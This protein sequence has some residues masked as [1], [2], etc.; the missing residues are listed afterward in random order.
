MRSPPERRLDLRRV[1][2]L[3]LAA[4]F[5]MGICVW[6][7][8]MLLR[9]SL[10]SIC[11]TVS[12]IGEEDV[13]L[14]GGEPCEGFA[15]ASEASSSSIASS[16]SSTASS[17]SVSTASSS[18]GGGTAGGILSTSEGQGTLSDLGGRRGTLEQSMQRTRNLLEQWAAGRAHPAASSGC[19]LPYYDVPIGVWYSQHVTSF[20]CK[21]YLESDA[22]AFRPFDSATR[23]EMAKLLV[24]MKGG[25]SGDVPTHRSFDDADPSAWYYPY[26]E[27]AAKRGWMKGYGDCY[28]EHPCMVRPDQPISRAEAAAMVVRFF[29]LRAL[30]TASPFVDVPSTAWYMR[31]VT[32]AADHCILKGDDRARTIRPEE[33]MNRAEMVTILSRTAH[34]IETGI[35]CDTSQG[36]ADAPATP[37]ASHITAR[38]QGFT[39]FFITVPEGEPVAGP[40]G[41]CGL[42][43]LQCLAQASVLDA[44]DLIA[45]FLS[46]QLPSRAAWSE[47]SR[48]EIAM[49]LAT[50]AAIAVL[51]FAATMAILLNRGQ[52]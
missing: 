24:K 6:G 37:P 43:S 9:A 45:S 26:L 23:A 16:T 5:A 7:G 20:F 17:S 29:Q 48:A 33:S 39:R 44:S 18:A 15:A 19:S 13:P 31:P 36:F 11:V 14:G 41:T 35:V 46:L 30:G 3:L 10:Q 12:V 4:F 1:R 8:E 51:G 47:A 2:M 49:W 28:G 52:R 34:E 38:P 50:T 21:G 22:A 42:P 25:L 40:S 27:E 32:T